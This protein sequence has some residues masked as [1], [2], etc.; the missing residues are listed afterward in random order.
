MNRKVLAFLTIPLAA[1]VVLSG[2]ALAQH[3]GPMGSGMGPGMGSGMGMM[4]HRMMGGECPM[5]GMMTGSGEMPAYGEGRIAFLKAELA[6]TD[7]QQSQWEGYAT[8]LKKNFSQMQNMRQSMMTAMSAKT[9]VER[10]DAHLS[11]MEGRVAILK[12]IKPKLEQLY[13]VLSD[14][15]KKKA[16]QLLTGM[17]CMM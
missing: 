5:M 4:G 14:D 2:A 1:A 9:P 8:A 12:E 11:A 3:R 10:L 6:I 15:Q 16:D 7:K 13:G 17:G